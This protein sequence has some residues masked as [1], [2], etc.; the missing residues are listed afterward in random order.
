[1]PQNLYLQS[2]KFSGLWY[3]Y[4]IVTPLPQSNPRKFISPQNKVH[5]LQLPLLSTPNSLA[6]EHH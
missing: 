4:E 3:I 1:M 2:V 5:A 6:L